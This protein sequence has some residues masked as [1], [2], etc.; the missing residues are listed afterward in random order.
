MQ[1]ARQLSFR[2]HSQA[3]PPSRSVRNVCILVGRA[4]WE[5]RGT[6]PRAQLSAG[7]SE[8]SALY[9][10]MGGREKKENSDGLA[11]VLTKDALSSRIDPVIMVPS[12]D[13]LSDIG[14]GEGTWP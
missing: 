5:G 8:R 11:K 12:L 9:L 4:A 6:H 13:D 3:S 1:Q 7:S 10:E 2:C 14:Q